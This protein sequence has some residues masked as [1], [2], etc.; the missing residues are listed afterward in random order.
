MTEQKEK[1][2]SKLLWIIMIL[3]LLLIGVGSGIYYQMTRDSNL[4]KRCAGFGWYAS[5]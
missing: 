1:K 5:G 4:N 3:L 2:K